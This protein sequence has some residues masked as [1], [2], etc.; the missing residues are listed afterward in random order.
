MISEARS[1]LG[2]AAAAAAAA[3][4]SV[5]SQERLG[6]RGG[7]LGEG[8]GRVSF[9][10]G[11]FRRGIVSSPTGNVIGRRGILRS[12]SS[13][14]P[15]LSLF[16]RFLFVFSCSAYSSLLFFLSSHL[17]PPFVYSS[18]LSSRSVPLPYPPLHSIAL[19][20]TPLYFIPLLSSPSLHLALF[21]FLFAFSSSRSSSC[22]SSGSPLDRRICPD[23]ARDPA[24]VRRGG[25]GLLS[26]EVL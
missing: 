14:F 6:G 9:G 4:D 15:L 22:L 24:R 23:R 19:H 10:F 11:S 2:P 1:Y 21:F 20:S 18:L 5:A 8:G 12:W 17:S 3:W 26:I 16:S 13:L 25:G 7:V